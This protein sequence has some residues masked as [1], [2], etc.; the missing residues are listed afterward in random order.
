MKKERKK[1]ITRLHIILFSML[2][3]AGTTVFFIFQSNKSNEIGKYKE[4][5]KDLLEITKKYKE[6]NEIEL[7]EGYELRIDM[8]T[9]VKEHY[10]SNEL[11]KECKGYTIISS[12]KGFD[13]EYEEE[14]NSYIKCGTKYVSPNYSE[15]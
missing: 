11:T 9:L 1:H 14:Y 10:L 4:L 15:F 5:Q 2:V 6:I 13:G 8:N 12:V 3:I 7:Q